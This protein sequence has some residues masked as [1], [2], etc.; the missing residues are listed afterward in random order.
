MPLDLFTKGFL[1]V[2]A[3][4]LTIVFI[5]WQFQGGAADSSIKMDIWVLCSIYFGMSI[6]FRDPHVHV[7]PS[8]AIGLRIAL[9]V[10]LGFALY[11]YYDAD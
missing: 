3:V 11:N 2:D 1:L 6:Y 5:V 10:L 9:S 8:T 7:R 4:V